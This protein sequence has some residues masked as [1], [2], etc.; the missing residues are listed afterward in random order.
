MIV[1]S[2]NALSKA[3][4]LEAFASESAHAPRSPAATYRCLGCSPECGR[5]LPSVRRILAEARAACQMGC[6]SCPGHAPEPTADWHP[7]AAE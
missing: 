2:C 7:L 5:C 4:I 6:A 3:R 1:C